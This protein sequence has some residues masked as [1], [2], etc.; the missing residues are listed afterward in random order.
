MAFIYSHRFQ[1]KNSQAR[2]RTRFD[3]T[4]TGPNIL[5]PT[6]GLASMRI[7]AQVAA[8]RRADV[9]PP[10]SASQGFLG[11]NFVVAGVGH[12]AWDQAA[13]LQEHVMFRPSS[14]LVMICC[15]AGHGSRGN[16][17]CVELI[18]SAAT[19]AGFESQAR[20]PRT[21]VFW[22]SFHYLCH[23]PEAPGGL[24]AS[25]TSTVAL[26][27]SSFWSDPEAQNSPKTLR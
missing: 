14:K 4:G 22:P 21:E 20:F 18:S 26:R 13:V 25:S 2:L 1:R 11:P 3:H 17:C 7:A 5:L 23:V 24:L 27:V 19:Q 8:G 12:R 15:W 10:W 6:P 9:W 16:Q